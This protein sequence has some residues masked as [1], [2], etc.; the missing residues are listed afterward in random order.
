MSKRNSNAVADWV[1]IAGFV[2]D[3]L[4][5]VPA[6][7]FSEAADSAYARWKLHKDLERYTS[8]HGLA[9]KRPDDGMVQRYLSALHFLDEFK[10]EAA[11][12]YEAVVEQLRCMPVAGVH[13]IARWSRYDFSAALEAA[14]SYV[15]GDLSTEKLRLAEQA[16]RQSTNPNRLRGRSRAYAI[17]QAILPLVEELLGVGFDQIVDRDK[18]DLPV[19]FLFCR[20]GNA[21]IRAGVLSFGPSEPSLLAQRQDEFVWLCAG[22]SLTLDQVIAVVPNQYEI[23]PQSYALKL[24][25]Q[26]VIRSNLEFYT[27]VDGKNGLALSKVISV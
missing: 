7:A 4:K 16:A 10:L 15:N 5:K 22:L 8:F 25:A 27:L 23:R 1:I 14:A 19:N 12:D 21:A 17:A 2:R 20:K 3:E 18:V 13:L 9:A 24:A 11:A 6:P 26:G